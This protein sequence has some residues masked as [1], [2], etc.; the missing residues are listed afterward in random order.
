MALDWKKTSKWWYGRFKLN[1]KTK[2]LNLGVEIEGKRPQ[3]ING[4]GDEKFRRSRE[5]AKIKHDECLSEIQNK[6]NLQKLTERMIELKTGEPVQ[7]VQLKELSEAWL[8]IP[9]RK[10]LSKQYAS[11]SQSRL[12]RFADYMQEHWSNVETLDSVTQSHV[13][14]FMEAEEKRGLSPKTWND[15]LKLLRT[16]F[17]HFQPE[18]DAYTQ[19][20]VKTPTR[21]TETVFRKP[22]SPEELKLILDAALNDDF[23]RPLIVTGICTAMR[24]GDCCSL[25]WRDVDLSDGFITV[26]T[27]KTGQTVCIPIFPMLNAEL[28]AR[29]GNGS[30]YV[31]PKQYQMYRRNPSGITWRVKKVLA[32]AFRR[33][34]SG[35]GQLPQLS[36]KETQ[37]KGHAYLDTLEN[38]PKTKRMRAVFDSYMK[39]MP[40]RELRERHGI[41]KGTQSHYLNEIETHAGCRVVMGR[42]DGSSGGTKLGMVHDVLGAKRKNGIRR[43]SVRDFH[44]FRVTWVTL[45]LTAGVPFELVRK[46]T[47]HKTADVVFKHYFQPG[48]EDFRQVLLSAMP[49]LLMSGAKSRDEQLR[50]VIKQMTSETLKADK[51]KLIALLGKK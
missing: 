23:I 20:L 43:A 1:D 13:S 9:R 38:T 10:E 40:G 5:R 11:V 19:Y 42:K 12:K 35:E 41:S 4:Q 3:S 28:Q 31:F 24:R 44:S 46:V 29:T 14:A 49:R 6:R 21:E 32:E 15:V 16:T 39:G 27:T 47:G 8:K 30:D 37:R 33:D 36:S 26:K 48:K 17:K 34:E 7:S 45:A 50:E 2:L 18:A 51:R 22:F 25:K